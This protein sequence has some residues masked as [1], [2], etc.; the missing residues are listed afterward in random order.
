MLISEAFSKFKAKQKNVQWSV[1]A[2]ND[3]NELVLSLW[4]QFFEK[5]SKETMTYVDRV[6]RW[7]G[8][9]NTGFVE[10]LNQAV[11][12]KMKIRAIVARS[13]RPDI[14]ASGGAANNLGNTFHPKLDWVG[15]LKL[16]DGDNFEIEFRKEE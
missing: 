13:K 9:G 14:V 16:W 3:S 6:S 1:S 15:V 5:R 8:A 10:N 7:G 2:I 12:E 11:K 4:N